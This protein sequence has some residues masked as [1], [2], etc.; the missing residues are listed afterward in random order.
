V[1]NRPKIV[2]AR[3]YM[4]VE[5]RESV[6]RTSVEAVVEKDSAALGEVAVVEADTE[7]WARAAWTQQRLVRHWRW[8]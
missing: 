6:G 7:D 5:E 4:S 8:S 2:G 3:K 1:A